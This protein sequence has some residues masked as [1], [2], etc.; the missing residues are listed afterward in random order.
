MLIFFSEVPTLVTSPI[1]RKPEDSPVAG[2]KKAKLQKV[3]PTPNKSVGAGKQTN[4]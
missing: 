1:K 3:T 2:N 4:D